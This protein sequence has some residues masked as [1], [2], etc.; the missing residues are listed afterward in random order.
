MKGV[1]TTQK[2]AEEY[3]TIAAVAATERRIK[4]VILD[5]SF[6]TTEDRINLLQAIKNSEEDY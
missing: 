5:A 3:I 1:E 6:L 2:T 4:N